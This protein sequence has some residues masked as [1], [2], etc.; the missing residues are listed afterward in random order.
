LFVTNILLSFGLS[1]NPFSIMA[2]RSPLT[3]LRK[4]ETK[5]KRKKAKEAKAKAK[6]AVRNKIESLRKQLYK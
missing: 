5:L 6:I 4:L 3:T 2:K 1:I